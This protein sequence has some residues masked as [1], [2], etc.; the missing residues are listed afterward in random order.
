MCSVRIVQ[1]ADG[2]TPT[3]ST[4]SNVSSISRVTN[5]RS[6]KR[7]A[8][9]PLKSVESN[10]DVAAADLDSANVAAARSI[11]FAG[12]SLSFCCRIP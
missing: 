6:S 8:K 9:A 3:A 5:A 7:G 2:I 1:A 12:L 11:S 4:A 10:A